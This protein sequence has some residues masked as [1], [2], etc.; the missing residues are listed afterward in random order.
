[1]FSCTI[2]RFHRKSY[3]AA[4]NKSTLPK[5]RKLPVSSHKAILSK[6]E[7][8]VECETCTSELEVGDSLLVICAIM[9]RTPVVPTSA[10]QQL[11]FLSPYLLCLSLS[12]SSSLNGVWL[13]YMWSTQMS[14]LLTHTIESSCGYGWWWENEKTFQNIPAILPLNEPHVA[15]VSDDQKPTSFKPTSIK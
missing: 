12:L 8:Q 4:Q 1:M 9:W 3:P 11:S 2:I 10:K 13:L 15:H 6:Q 5:A 7:S 14:S